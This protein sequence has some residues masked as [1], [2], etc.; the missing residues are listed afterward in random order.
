MQIYNSSN[1]NKKSRVVALGFF[2]GVHLG[3]RQLVRTAVE[4]AMILG[5]ESV[6]YTFEAPPKEL[7]FPNEKI[8]C[9][10][11]NSKKA[12]LFESL[13]V[14][15][16]IFENFARVCDFSPMEF[17]EKILVGELG[18]SHIVC[19][20]NFKFGKGNTGDIDALRS[21]LKLFNVGITVIPPVCVNGFSVS[22]GRIRAL[23]EEGKIEEAN[24]LLDRPFSLSGTVEHG[25]RIGHKLGFPT[26]NI[27]FSDRTVRLPNGVYFTKTQVGASFYLSVT[28]VGI[29]PTVRDGETIPVCETHI[30]D[31][32]SDIYGEKI[33]LDFFKMSRRE[34]CFPSFDLLTEAL[35]NDVEEAVGYF[36]EKE[37]KK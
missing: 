36:N 27:C 30:I 6:I 7:L 26:V 1:I 21:C 19:G 11:T 14:N 32:K 12:E 9:I 22:S 13:G 28:N 20:Y 8:R 18:A 23:L 3:H 33:C 31:F 17:V 5:V 2:D 16:V 25:H 4:K 24:I 29:R 35:K 10:D 37:E 34:I 15:G